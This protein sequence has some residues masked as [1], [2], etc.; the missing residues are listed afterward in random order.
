MAHLLYRKEYRN[1]CWQSLVIS[2]EKPCVY[3]FEK[4]FL[5]SFFGWGVGVGGFQSRSIGLA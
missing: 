2:M 3:C 4:V 1:F 5:F